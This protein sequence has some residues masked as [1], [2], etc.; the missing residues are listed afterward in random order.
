MPIFFDM[1]EE[2]TGD[3]SGNGDESD[4]EMDAKHD[5]EEEEEDDLPRD[6]IIQMLD[7]VW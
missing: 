3:Y 1:D 5:L 2:D 6:V 7:S 4:N